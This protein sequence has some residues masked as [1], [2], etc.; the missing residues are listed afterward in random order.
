MKN[1]QLNK[2]IS[3]LNKRISKEYTDFKGLYLYGSRVRKTHHKDSDVD[4]V[5]IFDYVDR[6]KDFEIRGIIC[7]L[8][9]EFDVFIDFRIFTI[10]ELSKNLI[11]SD[12][13]MNKG[14]FYEA[15]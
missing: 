2:L 13:V 1:N 4:I 7:E 15:A 6:A 14:L 3:E 12:E 11:Y 5:A 9:Y 10:E 8:M